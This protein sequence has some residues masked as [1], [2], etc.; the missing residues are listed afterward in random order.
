[1]KGAEVTDFK[2]KAAQTSVPMMLFSEGRSRSKETAG[3]Q[4]HRARRNSKGLAQESNLEREKSSFRHK[5]IKDI[6]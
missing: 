5:N 2:Q 4:E 1:M 3:Q 6:E